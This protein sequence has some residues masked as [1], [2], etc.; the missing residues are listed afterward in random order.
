MNT[1]IIITHERQKEYVDFKKTLL[2]NEYTPFTDEIIYE[3]NEISD[4][5]LLKLERCEY[6]FC[7]GQSNIEN[8][9]IRFLKDDLYGI[10]GFEFINS[11]NEKDIWFDKEKELFINIFLKII[12][13]RYTF[14]I[15]ILLCNQYQYN[16]D[17]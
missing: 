9:Q 8:K 16:Y 13:E 7:T 15:K 11:D 3:F 6:G 12:N 5:K 2:D 1:A 10:W 4:I 17:E 14:N